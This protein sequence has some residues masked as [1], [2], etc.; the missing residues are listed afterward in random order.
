MKM[1]KAALEYLMNAGKAEV[2][3]IDGQKYTTKR[4]EHVTNPSP[5]PIIMNTLT[6]LIE[7]VEA[8]VDMLDFSSGVYFVHVANERIA[9]L[10]TNLQCD[11]ER[12][13]LIQ[14]EAFTPRLSL[15]TYMDREKFNVML[16]SCFLDNEDRKRILSLVSNIKEEKVKNTFD[17]GVTQQVVAKAGV[18][19][20]G[21]VPVPN[22]VIL[23][24]FRT[25]IEVEQPESKFVF[26]VK[27]GPE[28]ALFEADGGEWRLSAMLRI[29]RYLED[30]F[31]TR[32]ISVKVLA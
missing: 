23:V 17:D 12:H 28:M 15:N 14:S 19:I 10:C 31:A 25:F 24:P 18:A 21:A 2:I 8:N 5:Q 22:P 1:I 16:Q 20:V 30:S 6:G 13:C 32:N 27:D 9:R 4:V 3:D 29:K 26:R 7:Y 11:A